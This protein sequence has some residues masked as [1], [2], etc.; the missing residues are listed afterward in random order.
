MKNKN[1]NKKLKISSIGVSDFPQL[2][3]IL[4]WSDRS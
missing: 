4:W 1:A 2:E 3:R